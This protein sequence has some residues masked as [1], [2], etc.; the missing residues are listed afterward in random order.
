M[1]MPCTAD[2]DMADTVNESDI[3]DFLANATWDIAQHTHTKSITRCSYFLVRT[4]Y[5]MSP[6]FL[7]GQ[8]SWNIDRHKLTKIN[9]GKICPALTVTN[10]IYCCIKMASS[11]KL[12]ATSIKVILGPT[13]Q[14]I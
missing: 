8:K 2:L 1:A 9:N 5:S 3:A 6:S 4:C 7:T 10:N 11:A 12:K 13:H 14:F